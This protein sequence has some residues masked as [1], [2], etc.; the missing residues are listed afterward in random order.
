MML[1]IF[2][3]A[4]FDLYILFDEVS[5]NIF[6]PFLNW[7]VCSLVEFH[8]FFVYTDPLTDRCFVNILSIHSPNRIFCILIINFYVCFSFE[9]SSLT[10]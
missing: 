1:S 8:E 4:Y 3:Y 6:F 5:V 2:S 9:T 7:I 10:H